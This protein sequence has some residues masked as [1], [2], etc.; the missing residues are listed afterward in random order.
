MLLFANQCI[1]LYNVLRGR[2]FA[3]V[4][5]AKG[6]DE[7]NVSE[8]TPETPLGYTPSRWFTPVSA[9]LAAVI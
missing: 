8:L 9:G 2:L 4:A 5:G 6:A 3:K 1:K 7:K